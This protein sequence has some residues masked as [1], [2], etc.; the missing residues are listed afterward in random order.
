MYYYEVLIADSR[1]HGS[2]PLT[3][4]S[5]QVLAN[6]TVVSVPLRSGLATGFI[7]GKSKKPSF[8]TKPLK[9]VLSKQPLPSHCL[10]L[11]EW[12]RDY[13]HVSFG[14]A[15]RQFAPSRTVIR[16]TEHIDKLAAAQ[17]NLDVESPLTREQKNAL[18][19]IK[20]YPD[21]TVLLH[22]DTGSGK[23]RVYLELAEQTIRSG[24]SVIILT[25]EIALT[26]QLLQAVARK[27]KALVFVVHSGLSVAERKRIWFKILESTEPV[28]IIGPRS[29]LFMP[30]TSPGLVIIDESHEPAYKQEQS[31]R[32]HANRVASQLGVLTSARVVL[33]S[34]TPS[35]TDYY[36]AHE[37]GAIVEM[38]NQAVTGKPAKAEYVLVDLKDRRHFGRSQH[39]SN[40]L[41]EAINESLAKNK[42]SMIYFNRRGSARII[43]C[44]KCGWQL[45]CPNCDVPLVY[46]GDEH[47][48]RC[49]I[50]GHN[51]KPPT[52]CPVCNNQDIVYKSIGTKTLFQEVEKLFPNARVARFDSDNETGEKLEETYGD[53]TSGKIDILVGT[54][55]LAKGLDLPKLSLVGI[56][57][58]ESSLSLPDYTAEERTYQLLYQVI[59]RV[60][61]GH[62]D[63]RVVLQTYHP[64]NPIVQAAVKRDWDSFY[65]L[66]IKER[67]TYRFPPFS[68]LMKLV[69]RRATLP[70]AQK[71]ANS[72]KTQLRS[73]NLPVEI[74]GPTPSFYA[75]RGKYFYY[76]LIVKSKS[77]GHLLELAA[78]VPA[79]W[80]INLDP[81]DLL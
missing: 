46:H 38:K 6:L 39:L 61:R 72:L 41:I 63:G 55:L 52:K 77:R 66:A 32:Y 23:T 37:R 35:L 24:C 50:C 31:P 5:E 1:Y 45:L 34:A 69:C 30:V 36:L 13:Y 68:Y 47:L 22:G 26:S 80:I 15:L 11:A 74:I 20:K 70:G 17:T 64:E 67:Q 56:I 8:A 4:S 10:E 75:R 71:A 76:Q 25:P 54:Q 59:G 65:N 73:E 27:L 78:A 18:V 57:S 7:A 81:S 43:L 60:G 58:A 16:R 53:L 14:E 44:N 29:A 33:G 79:G 42:Q 2:E 40:Q 9:A 12:L 21:T 28:V 62:N 49:H 51:A 3:Y 48:V 19:S